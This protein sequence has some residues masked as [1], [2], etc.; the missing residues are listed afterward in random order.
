VNL[1]VLFPYSREPDIEYYEVTNIQPKTSRDISVNLLNL[2][3]MLSL[4][5]IRILVRILF[6]SHRI[7]RFIS[8]D[9]IYRNKANYW[10]NV[11]EEPAIALLPK[12]LPEFNT[13]IISVRIFKNDAIPLCSPPKYSD[14]YP[15]TISLI[16][17]LLINS[18][19]R[20]IVE[21]I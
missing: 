7:S 21:S 20:S 6:I 16:P 5:L 4:I 14:P 3:Q 9:L 2:F 13:I 19:L 8:W 15:E 1:E 12:K 10:S 11:P 17:T 18:Y